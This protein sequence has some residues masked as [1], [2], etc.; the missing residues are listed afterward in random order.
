MC[1]LCEEA[2]KFSRLMFR[3]GCGRAAGFS[4]LAVGSNSEVGSR[5]VAVGAVKFLLP[6]C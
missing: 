5:Y 1:G 4:S 2:A 6:L 3:I